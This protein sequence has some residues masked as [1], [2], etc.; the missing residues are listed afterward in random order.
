MSIAEILLPE[1]D[2]EMASTR[3]MLEIVPAADAALAAAPE[4]HRAG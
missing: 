3:K 2:H 1:F 4:V